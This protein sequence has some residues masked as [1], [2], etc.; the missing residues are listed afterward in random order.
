M[1]PIPIASATQLRLMTS[2]FDLLYTHTLNTH[3]HTYTPTKTRLYI[4]TCRYQ[5]VEMDL[6]VGEAPHS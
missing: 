5:L 3:I 1:A 2:A 4:I 6:C